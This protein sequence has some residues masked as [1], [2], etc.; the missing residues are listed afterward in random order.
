MH[1]V[2]SYKVL[3]K[4]SESMW[5]KVFRVGSVRFVQRGRRVRVPSIL[6]GEQWQMLPLS[7]HVGLQ[8]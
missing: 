6:G 1:R 8:A 5:Q 7:N 4:N 2:I 3:T